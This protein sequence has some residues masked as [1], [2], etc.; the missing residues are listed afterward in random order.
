MTVPTGGVLFESFVLTTC[1][2]R[3][4]LI[5]DRAFT[6]FGDSGVAMTLAEF[7]ESFSEETNYFLGHAIGVCSRVNQKCQGQLYYHTLNAKFHGLSRSG[8][9][10]LSHLGYLMAL[11]TYDDTRRRAKEAIGQTLWWDA[12]HTCTGYGCC[13][14]LAGATASSKH[15]SHQ[16][17]NLLLPTVA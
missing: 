7:E 15:T 13:A 8:I 16:H 1:S 11:S 17:T 12:P 5:L 3:A 4:K 9:T 10:N 6:T 14:A 2:D